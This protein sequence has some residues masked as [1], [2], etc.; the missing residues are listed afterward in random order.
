[1]GL[2]LVESG[3]PKEKLGLLAVPL[4]PLQ[5]VLPL[6]L[7]KYTSNRPLDIYLKAVP[8][9]L[10]F[11]ILAAGLVAVTPLIVQNH[12]IPMYYYILLLVSYALHQV[13]ILFVG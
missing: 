4:V 12:V 9:R 11:G 13:N 2:K 6:I 5:I 7:A 10:M 3:I 1:M 8:Y